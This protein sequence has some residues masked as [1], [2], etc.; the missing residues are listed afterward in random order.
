[1]EIIQT[2][3]RKKT[4]LAIAH[5]KRGRGSITINGCPLPILNQIFFNQKLMK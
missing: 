2:Y 1:M 4:A 5:C 3:G